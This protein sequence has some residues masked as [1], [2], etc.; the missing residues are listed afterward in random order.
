VNLRLAA[1]Q[2]PARGGF[3]LIELLVVIG[4]IAIALAVLAPALKPA[5][6]RSLEAAARQ[7]TLDLE[8]ARQ[9]AIAERTKTRVLIP[10]VN[11][12]A[13]GQELA[14]R[15]YAVVSFNKTSGTWKQRGKWVRLAAPATFDPEPSVDAATELNV[16]GERKAAVTQINNSATGGGTPALF[17][18]AFIEFRS[19]GALG[20]DPDAPHEIIALADGIPNGSGGMTTKNPNLKYRLSLDPLTGSVVLR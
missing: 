17:T 20:L 19:T 3:T 2:T 16:I 8:N 4:V 9:I 1:Q 13:F 5:D 6:G 7:L 12:P 10:D 15:S 11:E 18:G 14:L